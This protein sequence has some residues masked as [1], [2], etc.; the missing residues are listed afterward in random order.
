M[1]IISQ[2]AINVHRKLVLPEAAEEEW[3]SHRE[4]DYV[5]GREREE[6]QYSFRPFGAIE[7][8]AML[9]SHRER[10]PSRSENWHH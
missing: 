10:N 4:V 1:R 9:G 3:D 8:G 6:Q 2:N 5:R 7:A